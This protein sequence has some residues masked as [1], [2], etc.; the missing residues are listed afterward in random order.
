MAC[1]I[2][3]K[4]GNTHINLREIYQTDYI[5]SV[6]PDC[7]QVINKRLNKVRSV[8]QN[9]LVDLM[10]RSWAKR[11]SAGTA[12]TT[13]D[14]CKR[15][16]DIAEVLVET[17][18]FS[19]FARTVYEASFRIASL[20]AEIHYLTNAGTIECMV[21]NKAV[22]EF[23]AGL[24]ARLADT[25]AQLQA[26]TKSTWWAGDDGDGAETPDDYAADSEAYLGEG[27]EFDLIPWR[28]LGPSQAFKIAIDSAGRRYAEPVVPPVDLEAAG[29]LRLLD[30]AK[31]SAADPPDV[32]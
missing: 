25:T 30:A 1:D 21:R 28:E 6:C 20:E 7:E 18:E 22:A 5:K 4:T 2:C 11:R 17:T 26:A 8:T 24:E 15:L 3:G 13:P 10:K 16:D 29:Q 19:K 9:I 14:L 12:M 27:D 32:L 31:S 23:I